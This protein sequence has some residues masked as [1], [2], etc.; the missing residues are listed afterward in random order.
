M[1]P[2]RLIMPLLLLLAPASAG[3]QVERYRLDP[4]HCQVLFFVDHLGFSTQIGRFPAVTGEITFDPEDWSSAAVEAEIEVASLYLGDA[5]WE[6]KMLS[7][8]FFGAKRFP[9]MRFVSERVEK[10]GANTGIVHGRLTL[11]GVTRP[12]ALELTVNRI[13]RNSFSLKHT[14]GFS[15]RTRLTR[16]AFGM[17][18][19]KA[20]V[21]DEVE[22]RLEIEALRERAR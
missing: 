16:S 7:D 2:L 21:G 4:V 11:R 9:T 3:A 6:K 17:T 19:M 13:G 14:A 15:A 5:A 22:I 10:T 20:A 1:I 8:D 18:R 12:L